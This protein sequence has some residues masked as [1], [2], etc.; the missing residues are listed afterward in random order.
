MNAMMYTLNFANKYKTMDIH[1]ILDKAENFMDDESA[2][3]RVHLMMLPF[4]LPY[5]VEET[6]SLLRHDNQVVAQ[7]AKN[8]LGYLPVVYAIIS[9]EELCFT[10]DTIILSLGLLR[11]HEMKFLDLGEKTK[12]I[13]DFIQTPV[14]FLNPFIQ[15]ALSEQVDQCFEAVAP[16]E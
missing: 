12:G 11:L 14:P 16:G 15:R 3:M 4:L 1:A 13:C 5:L 7:V 6:Q 10:D 9:D 8:L 2:A